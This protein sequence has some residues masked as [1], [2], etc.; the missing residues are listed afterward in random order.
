MIKSRSLRSAEHVAR[1]G[2][3]TGAYRAL[4]GRSEGKIPFGR[5]SRRWEGN[6]KTDFQEMG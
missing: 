5:P 6:S 1:M 3:R 4:V 2:D